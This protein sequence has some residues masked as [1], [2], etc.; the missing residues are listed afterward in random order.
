[1]QTRVIRLLTVCA[2]LF[3]SLLIRTNAATVSTFREGV[4]GYAGTQDT[5]ISSGSPTANNGAS[6]TIEIDQA[7]AGGE[8]LL[9]RFENIFGTSPTQIP[10]KSKILYATLTVTISNGGN[11]PMVHRM[12]V[13]WTEASTWDSLTDGIVADDAEAAITE[14][15]TFSGTGGLR[16]IPLPTA[17]LQ[18][19]SDATK[20]NHGWV[21]LPTGS[22]G[23]DFG[24]SEH[25]NPAVRPMLT[26]IWGTPTEPL[27]Q[28]LM[29][30]TSP[31]N[32]EANIAA[33]ANIQITVLN[34]ATKL[35]NPASVRLLVNSQSVTPTVEP[36]ANDPAQTIIT[37]D[38]SANF[39]SNTKIPVR[40]I[41]SD[42]SVPPRLSTNDFSF[43]TRSTTTMLV[44]ID[45]KQTW[46]YDR[47]ATDLG[48]AWKEKTFND[49]AWPSG[50]A[51]LANETGNTPEPIRTDVDRFNDAGEY[52]ATFYFR[53]HFNYSGPLG[54]DMFLRHVIDDGA[55]FY[56]NGVEIHRF[57]YGPG[58]PVLFNNTSAAGHEAAYEG[59]FVIPSFALVNGDNV[60]AVEVHQSGTGSSDFVFGAELSV[61]VADIKPTSVVSA[62]PAANATEVSPSAAIEITLSDGSRQVQT[63]SVQLTINGQAVVPRVEKT[64]GSAL[65]KI[66]YTAPAGLPASSKVTV[67][68][69]YS[70]NATPANVATQEFSFTTKG[71]T[72]VN[73]DDKTKWRYE[74]SGIDLG[75]AWREKNFNDSTWPEGAALIADETGATAEPIRTPVSRLDATGTVMPTMYFRTHFTFTG[76]PKTAQL[77][78]RHV[79]DDGAV[80]YLNGVEI[81]RFGL[82]AGATYDF[83][84]FFSGHEGNA[85]AGPYDISTASLV[86]GDNVLAVEVHQS[87]GGSSDIVFGAEIQVVAPP[88]V[89]TTTVTLIPID[90]KQKWRYENTGADLGTGWKDKAFNDAAWPEG[91]GLFALETGA[92]A[93]PIRTPIKRQSP[94]G[95]NIVTDYFR[96]HFT[97]TGDP[98]TTKLQLRHVVDDSVAVYLNGVEVHRFFLPATG[99]ITSATVAVPSDH[100][101]RYEGPFDIPATA[102]V[103][104]DNVIA[105]E[106]H[107]NSATSSDVVFGLEL[108]AVVSGTPPTS[109]LK[110]SLFSQAGVNLNLEWT[111]TGALQSADAITGPWVDV[112]AAKS[113]FSA[114]IAGRAKFYRLRQ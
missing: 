61:T 75:T 114:A 21:F 6:G 38:P 76:D 28:P 36:S 98:T 81:H 93:E 49:G 17:T 80:F 35:L 103:V 20:T 27:D 23:T 105:A 78:L 40:L 104:G 88:P 45:D 43:T 42:T 74:R 52:V 11:D 12:L 44:A 3:A 5:F 7:G 70:D 89:G 24:S 90:D 16:V 47:S 113:P 9:L 69:T 101:N 83:S 66:T 31:A 2:G 64:A 14:D 55:I 60:L 102:L 37:Y 97:F 26:V 94:A 85:Y 72:L 109:S 57:G 19:W 22:D 111:G 79:V 33:D 25:S 96:T 106:V 41:F 62:S 82:A 63:N 67:K 71:S 84:T 10:P 107:Q 8:F 92:T 77:K 34:G 110:F 108:K 29:T 87:D 39:A 56:L 86:Q 112:A 53:T 46:K 51:L 50:M 68:L 59:P 48:T 95:A 100:E 4:A 54:G 91:A 73:I 58:V 30:A 13:P 32:G 1:M 65:T 18:A 15:A 99:A